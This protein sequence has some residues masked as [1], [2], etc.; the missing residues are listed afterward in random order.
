MTKS[1]PA[2]RSGR[3]N[4]GASALGRLFAN[5]VLVLL[6]G[7]FL[8]LAVSTLAGDAGYLA[9]LALE[10]TVFDGWGVLAI[11][12][13]LLSLTAIVGAVLAARR[14]RMMIALAVS[15]L[16]LPPMFVT[17][18]SR[19][20]TAAA[21]RLMGWAALPRAALDWS[22]RIRPVTDR[23]EAEA[24]A[25]VALDKAGSDDATFKARRFADHWIVSTMNDDGWGGAHAVRIDTRT[26]ATALV[27]CPADR[28][29]CGMERP[30]VSDGRRVFRNER[31][32]LAAVFPASRPVC[33]A[34][35]HDDDDE[36]RGFFAM[37]RGSD[38]PCEV[39]DQSRQ[40]GVEV[41]D[42]RLNGC[43]VIDAP[44]TPWR[45]LS[46][47]T[48][49]LFRRPPMLGGKPS[50]ACELRQDGFI[51]VSVYAS[52]GAPGRRFHGFIVTTPAHLAEDVRAFE[53]FL[54]GVQIGP[55]G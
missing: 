18:G 26:G 40:M 8:L 45:P 38:I 51:Q 1:D 25:A 53:T 19:C 15:L 55:R 22:V 6:L 20:D 21:C 46:P 4:G 31:L 44:A 17:E 41:P 13:A 54:D 32:G 52:D 12:S 36:P 23:N 48:A 49:R 5:V 24:I 34:R 27:A 47:E 14:R 28:V 42:Y 9:Y 30:T 29:R 50:V 37:A 10:A 43:A 33:T 7:V 16:A 3:P 39:L 11:V 35:G 2:D